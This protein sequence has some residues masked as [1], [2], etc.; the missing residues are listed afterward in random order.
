MI[1]PKT[2]L[3]KDVL[4]FLIQKGPQ[5]NNNNNIIADARSAGSGDIPADDQLLGDIAKTQGGL[6][7][8]RVNASP[9]KLAMR[10]AA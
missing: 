5:T 7:I 4:N 3:E 9:S 2:D 6:S 8:G 10:S 1:E